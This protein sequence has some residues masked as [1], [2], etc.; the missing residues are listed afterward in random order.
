LPDEPREIEKLHRDYVSTVIY[1]IVGKPF[2]DWVEMKIKARN[3]DL[4]EKQDM[5]VH[6]DPEIAEILKNSTSISTSK[7]ISNS[8]FKVRKNYKYVLM[9][10]SNF[11]LIY[12]N[13]PSEDAQRL[14]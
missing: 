4:E 14:K 7:G 11:I 10:H 12:S 9:D 13:Q 1:T 3:S 5:N 6:L 2:S 8:L